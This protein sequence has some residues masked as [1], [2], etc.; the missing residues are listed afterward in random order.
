MKVF[1]YCYS[2]TKIKKKHMQFLLLSYKYDFWYAIYRFQT[3]MV[4]SRSS[5]GFFPIIYLLKSKLLNLP[6]FIIYYKVCFFCMHGLKRIPVRKS[7]D[8]R[9]FAF[10]ISAYQIKNAKC[11]VRKR[12]LKK[13]RCSV[14]K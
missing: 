8:Y 14:S 5:P 12:I 4:Y 10:E 13:V 3:K 9:Q 7:K 1:F 11:S 2:I 6:A